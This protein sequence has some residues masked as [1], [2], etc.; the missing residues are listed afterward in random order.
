ML[1]S[2]VLFLANFWA[3]NSG[4]IVT[5]MFWAFVGFALMSPVLMAD[6]IYNLKK[7]GGSYHFRHA[8]HLKRARYKKDAWLFGSF[9]ACALLITL[10]VFL[11]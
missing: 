7:V 11:S 10:A 8:Y 6:A 3:A 1:A 5:C 2:T 9:S 4:V